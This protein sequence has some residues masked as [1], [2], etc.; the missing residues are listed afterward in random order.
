MIIEIVYEDPH[1]FIVK[2]PA[3][4]DVHGK[5]PGQ[6][7]TLIALLGEQLGVNPRVLHPSSRLDRLV[8]GLVP[9]VLSG[10]AKKK[11]TK[12]YEQRRIVRLYRALCHG[13]PEKREGE[14]NEPI[15]RDPKRKSCHWINTPDSKLAITYYWLKEELPFNF[16]LI[17]LMPRTGRT[18][19]LRVHLASHGLPVVGDERYGGKTRITLNNGRVIPIN[20]IML[21]A[22]KISMLHPVTE[23]PLEVEIDLDR[24]FYELILLLKGEGKE[25]KG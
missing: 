9:V 15:G 4:I 1:L 21:Q 17:E 23:Q 16:S 11:I 13:V 19:Q 18:H 14:W 24:E 10:I 25:N 12:L 6:P 2:K 7:G 20:R 22:Y 3:G 5:F 8:S